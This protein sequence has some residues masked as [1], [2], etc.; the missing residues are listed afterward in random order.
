M[1]F[2]SHYKQLIRKWVDNFDMKEKK[3]NDFHCTSINI[4]QSLR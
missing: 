2:L 4:K 3:I 1:D